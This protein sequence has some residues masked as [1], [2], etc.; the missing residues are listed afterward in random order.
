MDFSIRR[1]EEKDLERLNSL[2]EEIDIYHRNELP[3]VFRKPDGPVR[4]RD[5]LLG[6]LA[7]QNTVIL[8][9]ETQDQFIGLLYAYVRSIPEIP[10]RIPC[11]VGEVDTI[12]VKQEYRRQGVGKAL[13]EKTNEWAGRMKLD[14]LELNVWNFNKGARDFYHELNYEPTIIRMWKSGPFLQPNRK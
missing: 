13:M 5:F 3:H 14:R 10:I 9:A 4:S 8:I 7:D 12:I 2:F 6:A 11:Q 1:V